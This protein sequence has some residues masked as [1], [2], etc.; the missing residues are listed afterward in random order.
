MPTWSQPRRQGI[1]NRKT[2]AAKSVSIRKSPSRKKYRL[3]DGWDELQQHL[4]VDPR[5]RPR[6]GPLVEVRPIFVNRQLAQISIDKNEPTL[7]KRRRKI[8]MTATTT[9]EEI[10]ESGSGRLG[11]ISSVDGL[12]S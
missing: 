12:R 2:A 8:I 11:E 4:R 6:L 10:G 7:I 9:V 1:A 5:T 3:T